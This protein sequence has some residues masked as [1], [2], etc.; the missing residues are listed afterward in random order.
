MAD[1]N[2][3]IPIIDKISHYQIPGKK[4]LQKLVYLIEKRVR[5]SRFRLLDSLLRTVLRPA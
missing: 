3:L 4:V 2:I 5:T 1:F